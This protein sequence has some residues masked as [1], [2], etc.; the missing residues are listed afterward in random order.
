MT[1]SKMRGN[2]VQS[3][4]KEKT[5][6]KCNAK[7]K[8]NSLHINL[9][10]CFWD[11]YQLHIPTLFFIYLFIS[12][13]IF[14][15]DLDTQ[16]EKSLNLSHIFPRLIRWRSKFTTFH[17]AIFNYNFFCAAF[18][19]PCLLSSRAILQSMR[20]CNTSCKRAFQKIKA[21]VKC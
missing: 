17:I 10:K 21:T 4:E 16:R 8:F 19:L 6:K 3:L 12:M 1:R 5:V 2:E 13:L 11:Y 15:L 20:N 9:N 14:P 18:L 7:R